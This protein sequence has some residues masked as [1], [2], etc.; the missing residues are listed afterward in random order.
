ML[1]VGHFNTRVG[2]YQNVKVEQCNGLGFYVWLKSLYYGRLLIHM[3]K[4]T[5]LHTLNGTHAITMNLCQLKK[6]IEG[7]NQCRMAMCW[8]Q[9]Q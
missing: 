6:L 8:I 4:C 1:V 2:I 3:P 7:R 9:L 5:N